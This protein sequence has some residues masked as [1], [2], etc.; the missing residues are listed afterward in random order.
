[1][2]TF[3]RTFHHDEKSVQLGEGGGF[4]PTPLHYIYHHVVVYAPAERADN[5]PLFLLYPYKY[6]VGTNY[7][8]KRLF[9]RSKE[10][11]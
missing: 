2:T 6:S 5:L 4:T 10:L 11:S 3:W 9:W 7:D 1:M 8:N